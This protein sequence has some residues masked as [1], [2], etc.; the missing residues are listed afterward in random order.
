[1]ESLLKEYI[2]SSLSYYDFP[3]ERSYEV[4]VL[5]LASLL[6]GE[7]LVQTEQNDGEGRSDLTVYSKKEGGFALILEFNHCGAKTRNDFLERES[8]AA[9]AQIKNRD[10]VAKA[11]KMGK[12]RIILFGIA[13]AG[14]RVSVVSE[15]G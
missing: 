10:Y 14:K 11:R 12:G 15:E 3:S 5:T 9:L 7:A 1:M 13:F 6:F 8:K 4:M 2:L